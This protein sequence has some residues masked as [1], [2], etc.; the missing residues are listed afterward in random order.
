[1]VRLFDSSVK[2]TPYNPA[3]A[4]KLVAA[5]GVSNPTVHL[6]VQNQTEQLRLAEF[7]QAEESA[8][9][10]NVVIESN[11]SA[12]ALARAAAGN[13]DAFLNFWSGGSDPDGNIF[14]QLTSSGVRNYSGY[15]SA[16][17]DLVLNNGRKAIDDSARK[18][19]YRVAQQ[20][21]LEDRP[22]IFLYSP[23]RF[24]VTSAN[25]TGAQL[26]GNTQLRV[27]FAQLK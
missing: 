12:T 13:Y 18:T 14:Q 27:A 21:L 11:D 1:M 5:S 19:L 4:R 20:I 17:F 23:I 26:T 22:I 15:S 8:V 24:A 16:R 25:V 6:L 9:G 10:I 7:I 2:C 3:D